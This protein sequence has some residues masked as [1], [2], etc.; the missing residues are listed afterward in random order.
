MADAAL[1]KRIEKLELELRSLK[2]QLNG[3]SPARGKRKSF[4]DLYGVWKKWGDISYE[5]I[6]AAEIVLPD[7]LE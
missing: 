7:G 5:Q 3:F 4:R 1:A 6:Q 2:A